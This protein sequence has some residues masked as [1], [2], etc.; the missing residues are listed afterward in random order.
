MSFPN[1]RAEAGTVPARHDL[2]AAR[3]WRHRSAVVQIGI[4]IGNADGT[5]DQAEVAAVREAC[6]A[7]RVDPGRF[8]L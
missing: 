7:L 4:M 5:F 8:G 6:Q 1:N 3:R 2:V